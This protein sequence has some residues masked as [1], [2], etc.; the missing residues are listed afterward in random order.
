M[1]SKE[2]R[3][4]E[5]FLLILANESEPARVLLS[6]TRPDYTGKPM[7]ATIEQLPHWDTKSLYP[8]LSSPEFVADLEAFLTRIK[9]LEN[10][11]DE[12]NIRKPDVTPDAVSAAASFDAIAHE[13]NAL[14]EQSRTVRGFIACFTS[15]EARND[16]AQARLSEYQMAGVR[17]GKLTTRLEAWLGS[18]EMH[19]LLQY[20][21]L[22]RDHRFAIQKAQ[23]GAQHQMSA[24][25]EDLA[26]SFGPVA[27][28]AW[29]KLHGNITARLLVRVALPDGEKTLPMSAVRGLARHKDSA[30]REAAYR[31]ELASWPTVSVPLAAALNSIKGEVN[32]LSERRGYADA[33][34]PSLFVN[35]IDRD[36][37]SAMQSAC[38]QSFPDFRRYFRAKARLLERPNG[39]K[40]FDLFA[41]V[42]SS[43]KSWSYPEA[44]EFIVQQFG[45]YS[46][47][48]SDYAARAFREDW[49][50]AEPRDGKRDGA[51][52]MGVR[53]DES[54][55]LMNFE[56]SLD[57]VSTLAHELGHGY[58]NLNLA[59]RTPMQRAT[60]MT[61][62]ET[63][64]IFCETII[65]NAALRQAEGQ[66]RL[67]ILENDI[68][69]QAQVVVDIHSR[70]LFESRV[71]AARRK[72]ELSVD[73]L[74][75]LMLEA[76]RETYGVAPDGSLDPDTLHPYM[77]AVKGHYYSGGLSYY[78]YPYTFGLLF[79]LGLYAI[80]QRDPETFKASYDDLLSSTGL[81]DA[82]T[83]ARRF[84]IDIRDEAFWAA[85]LDVIRARI[86]AFEQ[87]VEQRH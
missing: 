51:F 58:H 16:T 67:A 85:S 44:T 45:T 23:R 7:T 22:A 37:L 2:I 69:G 65:M 59:H 47:K 52:C 6:N 79:G 30:I 27:S 33:L 14:L 61:L 20:S 4:A 74:N 3:V 53:K 28:G 35:N 73:E 29:N 48:L 40:W 70:F 78:N 83:L 43:G 86:D 25:E 11:F 10:A 39:L 81:D 62:A 15:T 21:E 55:I 1:F 42:G 38:V 68:Q 9:A 32:T 49:I 5:S 80:Y 77:W 50:D 17:I 64:S 57:S 82:A 26:S 87:L 76:Q 8:S 66:E 46:S 63:A 71:F 12:H 31:A 19:A 36:T 18:L 84:G 75:T 41:P 56:P 72:R 24:L 54:R 13:W 34:E 60:P